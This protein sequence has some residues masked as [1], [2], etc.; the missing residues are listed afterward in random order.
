[1][2]HEVLTIPTDTTTLTAKLHLPRVPTGLVIVTHGAFDARRP[3]MASFLAATRGQSGLAVLTA[4]LGAGILDSAE[5]DDRM[6]RD[7]MHV[8]AQRLSTVTRWVRRLRITS[9]LPIGYF[10]CGVGGGAAYAAA[11]AC[12]NDVACIVTWEG[13]VDLVGHDLLAR[14]RIPALLLISD[15]DPML[16]ASTR[17]SRVHLGGAHSTK[18]LQASDTPL[19]DDSLMGRAADYA[20][21]WLARHLH[22][23]SGLRRGVSAP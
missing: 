11:V 19:A 10:A 13:R 21:P 7:A 3:D 5:P 12:A 6:R 17:L 20:R 2:L 8:L 16:L 15:R 23:A 22:E 4:E 1:M 14:V 9:R 18:V